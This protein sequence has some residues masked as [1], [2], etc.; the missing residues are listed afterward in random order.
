MRVLVE[1]GHQ[2]E[3]QLAA[4]QP[5][6]IAQHHRVGQRHP[7]QAPHGPL[8]ADH[9]VVGLVQPGDD[10]FALLRAVGVGHRPLAA[11][12][13]GVVAAVGVAPVHSHRQQI[14]PPF[15]DQQARP[16]A[17]RPAR[18]G[19]KGQVDGRVGRRR[20]S[21][22]GDDHRPP[23]AVQLQRLIDRRALAQDDAQRLHVVGVGDDARLARVEVGVAQVVEPQGADGAVFGHGEVEEQRRAVELELHPL[24][25]QV[26]F[27]GPAVGGVVEQC[28][29]AGHVVVDPRR[30][31]DA[32]H[33]LAVDV[34][35]HH[36]PQ[37]AWH[38]DQRGQRGHGRRAPARRGRWPSGPSPQL[39]DGPAGQ[40]K[41][42][43]VDRQ[44]VA[45]RLHPAR[46][47]EQ[48][49]EQRPRQR[50]GVEHPLWERPVR[51]AGRGA[52]RATQ[53]PPRRP[54]DGEP[55]EQPGGDAH[56]VEQ[57]VAE[58][59]KDGRPI[60]PLHRRR[61]GRLR[62][63]Q[64][65]NLGHV[66]QKGRVQTNDRLDGDDESARFLARRGD[67]LVAH[68]LRIG[69]GVGLGHAESQDGH[70]RG[71]GDADDSPLQ[72]ARARRPRQPGEAAGRRA[73][74]GD[75]ARFPPRQEDDRADGDEHR[76]RRGIDPRGGGQPQRQPEQRPP[77]QPPAWLGIAHRR[78]PHGG[79]DAQRRERRR[80]VVHGEEV[81]LLDGHDRQGQQQ[82]GEQPRPPVIQPPGDQEGEEDADEIDKAGQEAADQ[83]DAV[84]AAVGVAAPVRQ[85]PGATGGGV[86]Q[87]RGPLADDARRRHGEVA[88][89]E[90]RIA[91]V[92]GVQCGD[93]RAQVVER[94]I[95]AADGAADHRQEALVR[96]QV[97][98]AVPVE[99]DKA[100]IRPQQ[101]DGDESH[102]DKRL[103]PRAGAGNGG[104]G[105]GGWGEFGV[106]VEAGYT[107]TVA[108]DVVFSVSWRR[109]WRWLS[110]NCHPLNA[111][112]HVYTQHALSP[113]IEMSIF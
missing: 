75:D 9:D 112:S 91:E 15:V 105:R 11:G 48:E 42:R 77:A 53:R 28:R 90:E 18:P 30:G 10:L 79:V 61:E 76:Q 86:A 39:D 88:I 54:E 68:H 107:H 31:G 72:V 106:G 70:G 21:C 43:R 33:R 74:V 4:E 32:R 82:R 71:Q 110:P 73:G 29:P 25:R 57:H 99:A 47:H 100:E 64:P 41:Q 59:E 3:A 89:D 27:L 17:N 85:R 103:P 108:I 69:E 98:V 96:V 104:T 5:L 109:E 58:R 34:G 7:R 65:L 16:G 36:R 26:Q 35:V 95:D 92:V 93:R 50:D 45:H 22:Q 56:A 52:A 94:V 38:D 6:V 83:L 13:F 81:G 97:A 23:L 111:Q 46:A 49:V 14:V 44:E 8:T 40:H 55:G 2:V 20:R 19:L 87:P 113:L 60:D 63:L 102:G 78:R 101:Q 37:H 67:G 84:V 24:Q 12:H 51:A 80:P 1:L 62:R 66:A